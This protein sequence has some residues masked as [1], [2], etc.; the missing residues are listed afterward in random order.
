MKAKIAIFRG[1]QLVEETILLKE[2]QK[3]NMRKQKAQKKLEKK[4]SQ[5]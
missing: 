2:I 1:N 5:A 4:D 3:S